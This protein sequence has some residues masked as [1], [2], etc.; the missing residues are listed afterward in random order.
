MK[1]LLVVGVTCADVII[2]VDHLPKTAEDVVVYGQEM[3]L[4]GCAFNAFWVARSLGADV[5]LFSPIGRGVYADF[6]RA[7]L[8]REGLKSI[9][10]LS[11]GQDG[12]CYCFVEPGGERTFVAYHGAEY[13]YE[14]TWLQGLDMD[15]YDGVYVCGLEVEE[16]TG[17]VL[18]DFLER[19]CRAKTVYFTPGPRPHA[20]PADLLGRILSLSPVLHM[21]D[22]EVM[23]MARGAGGNPTGWR[24][25]A[26]YLCERTGA[27]VIVTRGPAGSVALT[28]GE[29]VVAPGAPA[30]VVDTIGAGDSHI[31]AVMAA[32]SQGQGMFEALSCANRVAARVCAT[33]G[34]HVAKSVLLRAARGCASCG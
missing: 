5:D 11:E 22:S 33:A 3:T 15:G 32:L 6:V 8:E 4:G 34:A 30:V 10:P 9:A 19:S 1:K 29:E 13:L 18:V 16:R 28:P 2:N 26:R 12:C 21:N 17:P 27:P 20:I 7:E 14:D 31:G 25:A 23:V 24:D